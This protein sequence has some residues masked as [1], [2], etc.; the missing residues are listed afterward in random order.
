MRTLR[1]VLAALLL[2]SFSLGLAS[3]NYYR[4]FIGDEPWQLEL[5]IDGTAVWGRLIHDH[6]PLQLEAGGSYDEADN[7]LVARFGL[8]GGE[9]MGT[10]LGEPD[11]FGT[12]EGSFLAQDSLTPF[13]FELI[14][15]HVDYS[16]S[17][18]R[19]QAVSTY[20]FFSSP[21]MADM[22]AFVQPDLLA[23]QIEFVELAQ[24]ADLEGLIRHD[25]W[26]ESWVTI[27]YAA[28]ALLSSL[29]TVNHY[30]GGAHQNLDYWSYNLTLIGTQPR[31]FDLADLFLPDSNWLEQLSELV[32]QDLAGQEQS[33]DWVLDGSITELSASDLEVFL[34]SPSGLRFIMAPY[35]VGPWASG[36]F[37]VNLPLS[38]LSG[39]LDPAGPIKH[40]QS[41]D[42][43]YFSITR[44]LHHAAGRR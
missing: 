3:K 17:Q 4:G 9:L 32:L 43:D 35:K 7:S 8:A 39:L 25:W 14:A 15:Q 1:I 44:G 37:L 27:E 28:P 20:P 34:I 26:F 23:E 33:A 22:N 42:H 36:T 31:P 2:G 16:Y 18:A 12:F 6:L 11:P 24:Q 19:I 30:T 41:A 40:L 38:E 21:R 5:S 13:R 10:M 29:V